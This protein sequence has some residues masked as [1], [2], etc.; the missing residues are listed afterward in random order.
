MR[1]RIPNV[2][3]LVYRALADIPESRTDDFI[4]VYEVWKNFL[5]P[6]MSI[7]T[8]FKYHTELGIPSFASIIRIRRKLQKEYPEFTNEA[9]AEMRGEAEKDYRAY[10]VNS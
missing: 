10:A 1:G 4:L 2:Q 3:P 9:T 6:E 7:K 8:A 5:P